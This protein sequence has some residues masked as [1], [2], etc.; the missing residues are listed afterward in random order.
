V[1]SVVEA[2]LTGGVVA[3]LQRANVPLLR[4]NHPDVP[5][6]EEAA[7]DRTPL[8]LR[9]LHIALGAVAVMVVLTPIGLLAPGGAFGEDSPSDLDLSKYHLSAIPS[10]L[11]KWNGL[12][13][14]AIFD[15]YDFSNDPHP[16]V[17]YIVSALVGIAVIGTA[18]FLVALAVRAIS[19]TRHSDSGDSPTPTTSVGAS[20]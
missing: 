3:Y 7:R 14:H 4:V 6:D 10:G 1:A 5:V 15:G 16:T 9:P 8:R 12:W 2:V 11:Q 13:H 20:T 17:G 18:I 19:R